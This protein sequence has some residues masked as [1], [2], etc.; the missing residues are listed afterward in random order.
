M[1]NGHAGIGGFTLEQAEG[2]VEVE[3]WEWWTSSTNGTGLRVDV[4]DRD[5]YELDMTQDETRQLAALLLEAA[6]NRD[7]AEAIPEAMAQIEAKELARRDA[8][9]KLRQAS[10]EAKKAFLDAIA[11]QLAVINAKL[12]EIERTYGPASGMAVSRTLHL[13]NLE[14][15]F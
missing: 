9:E 6:G 3:V 8:D 15:A 14:P 11:P 4:P 12:D 2:N 7:L 13:D 1:S 5:A 10:A